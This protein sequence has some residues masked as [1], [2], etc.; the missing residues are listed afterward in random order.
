MI[1]RRLFEVK[2]RELTPSQADPNAATERIVKRRTKRNTVMKVDNVERSKKLYRAQ[3]P[4]R[5]RLLLPKRLFEERES[6][7]EN[8]KNPRKEC[9]SYND[10]NKENKIN[11]DIER[12]N[13][14]ILLLNTLTILHGKSK[15]S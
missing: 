11:P 10:R 5:T 12:M 7:K 14:E 13:L 3:T 8:G 9:T 4:N 15:Q 2:E 1:P 6:L